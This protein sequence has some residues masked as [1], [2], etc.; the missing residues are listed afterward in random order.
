MNF[1]NIFCKIIIRETENANQVF[2]VNSLIKKKPSNQ[3]IINIFQMK[4]ERI[5]L[6]KE[7]N[8]NKL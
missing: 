7:S 6:F 5:I 8:S 3:N 4:I 1:L 2:I